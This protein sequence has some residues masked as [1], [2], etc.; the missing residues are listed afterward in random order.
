VH[1]KYWP[2]RQHI[3]WFVSDYSQSLTTKKQVITQTDLLTFLRSHREQ[4]GRPITNVPVQYCIRHSRQRRRSS[5]QAPDEILDQMDGIPLQRSPTQS[6]VSSD[7][8]SRKPNMLSDEKLLYLIPAQAAAIAAFQMMN[9]HSVAAIAV[10]DL[11]GTLVAN[12]SASDLRSLDIDNLD[13][14]AELLVGGVTEFV[15]RVLRDAGV[16]EL[17]ESSSRGDTNG[18]PRPIRVH[19][20]DSVWSAVEKMAEQRMHRYDLNSISSF[21]VLTFVVCGLLMR[22]IDQLEWFQR[23][24]SPVFFYLKLPFCTRN[25]AFWP[26]AL[27]SSSVRRPHKKLAALLITLKR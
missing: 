12:V 1:T 10:L 17:P 21:N 15:R 11:D 16:Q 8:A 23:R 18:L 9:L 24:M 7:S 5:V 20:T 26:E 13:E 6:T 3:K 27:P 14:L 2:F 19:P 25:E 4:I 22:K